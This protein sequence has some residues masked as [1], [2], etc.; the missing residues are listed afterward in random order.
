MREQI[1]KAGSAP[2]WPVEGAKAPHGR[3][4]LDAPYVQDSALLTREGHRGKHT[5]FWAPIQI[6]HTKVICLWARSL[7]R[8]ITENRSMIFMLN[9]EIPKMH[10]NRIQSWKPISASTRKNNLAVSFDW[11]IVIRVSSSQLN[12]I[13]SLFLGTWACKRL[14][15]GLEARRNPSKISIFLATC[16]RGS[17]SGT[18]VTMCLNF[19][20]SL[21]GQLCK[22]GSFVIDFTY[23]YHA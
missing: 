20:L 10:A 3:P 7:A 23:K 13:R 16:L 14:K 21:R 15:Y 5:P 4:L 1:H 22:T 11:D 19:S 12:S 6:R 17:T 18:A 2:D 8:R 9:F